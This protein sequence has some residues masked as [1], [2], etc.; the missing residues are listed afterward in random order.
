[1]RLLPLF[2]QFPNGL[3]RDER[4]GT[5]LRH[6]G[7]PCP[8]LVPSPKAVLTNG[9]SRTGPRP[10]SDVRLGGGPPHNASIYLLNLSPTRN[11][12]TPSSM[13]AVGV[14]A[15]APA[16][17]PEESCEPLRTERSFGAGAF[18][19][20]L[21]RTGL[22]EGPR[23]LVVGA[24]PSRGGPPQDRLGPARAPLPGRHDR[25]FPMTTRTGPWPDRS[26]HPERSCLLKVGPKRDG[27]VLPENPGRDGAHRRRQ[28]GAPTPGTMGALDKRHGKL[29]FLFIVRAQEKD[30]IIRRRP[31]NI[32]PAAASEEAAHLTRPAT[33]ATC[34]EAG[35]WSA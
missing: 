2:L 12:S 8:R 21:R 6:A 10:S 3:Y 34:T 18:S 29:C 1:V 24:S 11:D 7:R 32:Y 22:T 30:L 5:L 23:R 4:R 26:R 25:D 27:R 31:S 9:R 17:R 13:R 19:K 35:R 14:R 15:R 28:D 20:G 16:S 33:L